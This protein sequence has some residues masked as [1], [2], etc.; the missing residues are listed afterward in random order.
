M[1]KLFLGMDIESTEQLKELL[2]KFQTE[3]FKVVLI[4]V[5]EFP[6]SSKTMPASDKTKKP[7]KGSAA[8]EAKKRGCSVATIYN[9]RCKAKKLHKSAS[10]P[11]WKKQKNP[12]RPDIT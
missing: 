4:D 7:K 2:E 8:A 9:E 6:A 5:P 3:R 10:K 1:K 12:T 11:V